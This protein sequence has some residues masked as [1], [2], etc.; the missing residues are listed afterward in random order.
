MYYKLIAQTVVHNIAE[1][2]LQRR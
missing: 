1:E 2:G